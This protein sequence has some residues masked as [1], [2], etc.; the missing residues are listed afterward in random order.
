MS[1]AAEPRQPLSPVRKAFR[2]LRLL[3]N[4]AL[5]RKLGTLTTEGYLE[6]T[7]WV[8]SVAGGRV[9]TSAGDAVPWMTYPFI[10]FI[11]PRLSTKLHVFEYGAGA[12]TLYFSR[13]VGRVSAVEHDAAF[14]AQLRPQLPAHVHLQVHASADYITA[15]RQAGSAP[16]LV[17]VDGVERVACVQAA[18]SC[19]APDGV[20]V[21]DDSE[22]PEYA[23]ARALMRAAGFR[24]LDFW[25]LSPGRVEHRC[26][27]LFYRHGNVLDV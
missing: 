17:V 5:A 25:G 4:P 18:H 12:S 22:R 20:L 10:D 9:V 23:P 7:G 1:S 19:L 24:E 3:L 21:L 16:H 15:V 2:F 8:R 14:A 6:R 27:T 11:G 26:T 13:R